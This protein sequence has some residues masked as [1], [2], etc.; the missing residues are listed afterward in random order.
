MSLE[1]SPATALESSP[2]TRSIEL[3]ELIKLDPSLDLDIRY[4]RADNFVGYPVY[5]QAR[6]FLQRPAAESLLQAHR[7]LRDQGYGLVIFDGYRPW[8]VTKL[9]WEVTPTEKRHFV[10]NPDRGSRHNRG[11]AVDL[12]LIDLTTGKPVCMPSEFDEM[13]ERSHIDYTGGTAEAQAHRQRLQMAMIA[14]GFSVHPPEWWHYDYPDW[15]HYPILDL[16]FA[17]IDFML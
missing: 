14:A 4:A 7:S 13:T 11:C 17:E 15:P 16:T 1:S 8:S 12:S 10:A 2:A 9:F 3:V 5:D 6:A